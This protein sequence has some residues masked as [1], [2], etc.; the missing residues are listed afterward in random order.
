MLEAPVRKVLSDVLLDC[1]LGLPLSR[2]RMV[3]VERFLL[4][5]EPTVR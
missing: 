5:S 1:E 4:A 3:Q 2:Q